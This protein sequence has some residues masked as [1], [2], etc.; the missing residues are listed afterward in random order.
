MVFVHNIV[1]ESMMDTWF[2][3]S[4]ELDKGGSSVITSLKIL[5]NSPVMLFL[6]DIC[7]NCF[8]M[9]KP[10]FSN[11]LCKMNRV[12][13][14]VGPLFNGIDIVIHIITRLYCI[15]KHPDHIT[16]ILCSSDQI[17][18]FDVINDMSNSDH[19]QVRSIKAMGQ[20]IKMVVASQTI[21]QTTCKLG[22][23]IEG[24]HSVVVKVRMN[25]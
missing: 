15:W 4:K 3:W 16:N 23:S 14:N 19:H 6:F 13:K 2:D 20:L 12:L 7:L 1:V 24:W 8:S 11:T 10:S 9:C 18:T 25:S 5:M 21:D 22:N 17:Q